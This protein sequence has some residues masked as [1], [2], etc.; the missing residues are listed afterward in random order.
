MDTSRLLTV[1][2]Y[3][4]LLDE[5]FPTKI[6]LGG[7]VR[8]PDQTVLRQEWNRE[9]ARLA[10]LRAGLEEVQAVQALEAIH[11]LESSPLFKALEERFAGEID[12]FDAL[13][14]ADRELLEFK[15]G[16]DD[17]AGHVAWPA[18]VKEAQTWLSDLDKLVAQ[19]GTSDEK[20]RAR[21]LCEQIN[22]IIAEKN[23]DRLKK[24]L[25]EISDVYSSILYRQASF[26]VEYFE[27]LV[28]NQGQMRDQ[29]MAAQVVERGRGFIS[30][31]NLPELKNTVYQLQE[32][33]PKK[34]V[35]QARRGYGSGLVN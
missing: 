18:A 23:E 35:E 20:A 33:L 13:L 10:D 6:E 9:L 26:W 31:D 25:E 30:E 21:S 32:L 19:Q 16:L 8:Q 1:V 3:V 17:I 15:V 7:K 28:R 27:M 12:D 22:A 34:I 5:E 29:T 4:P 2:A 14:Q 11:T 24:K